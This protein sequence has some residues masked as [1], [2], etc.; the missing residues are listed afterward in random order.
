MNQLID[1]PVVQI[2][3]K[4]DE[5]LSELEDIV[6]EAQSAVGARGTAP[7][8]SA[9]MSSHLSG[10]LSINRGNG[11]DF[12]LEQAAIEELGGEYKSPFLDNDREVRELS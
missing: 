9:M 12:T 2:V 11:D 5:I 4:R 8:M 10:L 3:H 1:V 7:E 6:M